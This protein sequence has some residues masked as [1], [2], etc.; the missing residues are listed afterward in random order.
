[1]AEGKNVRSDR[2]GAQGRAHALIL[3]DS[4]I[5]VIVG[6]YPESKSRVRARRRGL[7][8]LDTARATQRGDVIF[9][10]FQ[11]TKCREFM[12]GGSRRIC[13]PA[14]RYSSRMASRFIIALSFPGQMWT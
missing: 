5:N 12:R 1:L 4:G 8:V 13:E 10:R 6:L 3:S 11:T 2:F 14:K 9:L 7:E